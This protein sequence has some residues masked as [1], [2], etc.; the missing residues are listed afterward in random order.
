MEVKPKVYF[1]VWI[2]PGDYYTLLASPEATKTIAAIA[3]ELYSMPASMNSNR[4]KMLMFY[5]CSMCGRCGCPI[6]EQ[7]EEIPQPIVDHLEQHVAL[8]H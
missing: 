1:P 8:Y 6:F 3:F 4:S 2:R 7:Q 5:E